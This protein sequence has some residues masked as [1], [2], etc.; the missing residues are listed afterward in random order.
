LDNGEIGLVPLTLKEIANNLDVHESTVSRATNEKYVQ[1]PRG[2]FELKYF[3]SSELSTD[4]GKMIS[5]KVIMKMIDDLIKKEDK[6]R[7]SSDNEIAKYFNN[8]GI[9]VARRTV[10]KY[11]ERLNIES[12]N[13][14]KIKN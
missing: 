1:T 3:F 4:T 11:R 14:R 6:T 9:S 5:S 13:N 7:P 8:H 10:A 12:S 2:T